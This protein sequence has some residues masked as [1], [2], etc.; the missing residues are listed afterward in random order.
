MTNF[1]LM[2]RFV[3]STG[4]RRTAEMIGTIGSATDTG[5]SSRYGLAEPDPMVFE[6]A[7]DDNELR[8]GVVRAVLCDT[9]R[10]IDRVADMQRVGVHSERGEESVA[11]MIKMYAGHDLLH[12]AQL[13]RIRAVVA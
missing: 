11:H 3:Q 5:L 12:L 1:D 2:T 4:H 7:R 9:G 8:G 6:R 13:E 10:H